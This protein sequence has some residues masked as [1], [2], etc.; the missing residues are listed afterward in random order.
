M[1]HTSANK[2]LA[3]ALTLSRALLGGTLVWVGLVLGSEGL[4]LALC[5]LVAAWATDV[6]DGAVARRDPTPRRSWVGEHDVIFDVCVA[7]GCAP[8]LRLLVTYRP[9]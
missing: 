9:W 7:M 3:D 4:P 8:F 6:L 1:D 5:A 2:A